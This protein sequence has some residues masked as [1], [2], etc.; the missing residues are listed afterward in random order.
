MKFCVLCCLLLLS[1]VSASEVTPVQKVIQLMEG[2]IEKGKKEKH[3]EQVQFAAFKQ[4]CADTTAEK[5]QAIKEGNE[6]IEILKADI[7]QYTADSTDHAKNVAKLEADI[8]T[9]TGDMKAATA[10][11]VIDKKAYDDT[12]ASHST[13][14]S[15]AWRP[16]RRASSSPAWAFRAT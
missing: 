4:F 16:S 12:H 7:N 10:V 1:G 2:M 14:N 3:D 11:R 9:W 6:Q 15:S 13:A 5:K 8:A